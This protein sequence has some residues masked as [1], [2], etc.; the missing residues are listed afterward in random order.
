MPRLTL[1]FN[2]YGDVESRSDESNPAKIQIAG[3]TWIG[4]YTKW[5]KAGYEAIH[6]FRKD[7]ACWRATGA[8]VGLLHRF[9][10]GMFGLQV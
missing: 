9:I 3:E 5:Y 4:N 2:D 1:G 6:I 10:V 7:Q 8:R